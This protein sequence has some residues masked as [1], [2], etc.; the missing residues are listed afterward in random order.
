MSSKNFKIPLST[1]EQYKTTNPFM[2]VAN[3]PNNRPNIAYKA[4]DNVSVKNIWKS[5]AQ[6][7]M[8]AYSQGNVGSKNN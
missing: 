3:N 5:F 7:D 8:T 6:P 4:L 2:T 1:I